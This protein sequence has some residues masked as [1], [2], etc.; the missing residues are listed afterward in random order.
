[1][2]KF[3]LENCTQSCTARILWGELGAVSEDKKMKILLIIPAYNEGEG[4]LE[5]LKIVEDY[6]DQR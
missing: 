1:M 6:Q 5:N 3:I 2:V 4:I